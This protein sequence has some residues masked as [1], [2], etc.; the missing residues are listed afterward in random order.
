M[1]LIF[2]RHAITGFSWSSMA[3]AIRENA[4][5]Q[6]A[7]G[8][9]AHKGGGCGGLICVKCRIPDDSIQFSRWPLF[10]AREVLGEVVDS[11]KEK[12]GEED[13]T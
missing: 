10:F 13:G 4:A 1:I 3:W 12:K 7:K 11:L 9:V 6:P 8:S 2:N 5:L